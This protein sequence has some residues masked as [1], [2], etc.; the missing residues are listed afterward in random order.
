MIAGPR[1]ALFRFGGPGFQAA[2]VG[3]AGIESRHRVVPQDAVLGDQHS[4]RRTR[5]H[6]ANRVR[7]HCTR[8]ER[9]WS[10]SFRSGMR[11]NRAGRSFKLSD[12]F[13]GSSERSAVIAGSVGVDSWQTEQFCSKSRWPSEGLGPAG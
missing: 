5:V 6:P 3:M 7:I 4:D 12:A 2:V 1:G 13:S 9:C 8:A 10:L 11:T